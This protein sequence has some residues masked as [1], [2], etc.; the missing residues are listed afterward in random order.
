[1]FKK[2]TLAVLLA[3]ALVQSAL[4]QEQKTIK[5][6]PQDL[7]AAIRSL[8]E[9][10]G[11]QVLFAAEDL[12]GMKSPALE[13]SMP[14][15]EAL[16]RLLA[17]SGYSFKAT[18]PSTYVIERAAGEPT[19]LPEV[20]VTAPAES[21]YAVPNATAATKMDMPIHDIPQSIEVRGSQLLEDLGGTHNVYEAGKTVAG[22]FDVA[23]GNASPGINVPAFNIRGYASSYLR[24]GGLR[25]NGWIYTMDMASIDRI[26]FLK[27]PASVLYGSPG[28][29]GNYGGLVNYVSKR[30]RAD[31]LTELEFT[32]GSYDYYR[33]SL[34]FNHA[35]NNDKSLLFRF[36]GAYT[37]TGSFVDEA[38]AKTWIVAPELSYQLT[39]NDKLTIL[40][41]FVQSRATPVTGLPLTTESFDVPYHRNFVDPDFAHIDIDAYTAFVSYEHQFNPNW[42]LTL[43]SSVGYAY[44]DDYENNV[45]FDS[46]GTNTWQMGGSY[47]YF[48]NT[49]VSIDPRL[50]GK[51]DTGPMGH[52]LLFGFNWQ[53]DQYNTTGTFG[54]NVDLGGATL[55]TLVPPANGVYQAAWNSGPL[56]S[57]YYYS[58][59]YYIAPYVQDLIS[60]GEHVK[61]LAGVRYDNINNQVGVSGIFAS[62]VPQF[63]QFDVTSDHFSPRF[64]AVWQ[65]VKPTSIYASYSQGYVPNIGI[66]RD[67]TELPPEEGELMEVGLKQEIT[68]KLTANLAAYQITQKNMTDA[69]PANTPSE[70]FLILLGKTRSQGVELD[71]NGQITHS[72]RVTAAAAVMKAW[73]V[74]GNSSLPSGNLL[75]NAPAATF[76]LFGVYSFDG[77]L[78]GLELGGGGYY[79]SHV[80][81][82]SAH[83]MVMP[84]T[85]QF[86]A[87]T[88]YRFN[89]HWRMQVDVKNLADR[90]NYFAS[91]GGTIGRSQP[92][93]AYA[94]LKASF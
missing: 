59:N 3:A 14:A 24:D 54:P 85:I 26:E 53:M 38:H 88:A 30:P 55:A 28:Q 63:D 42:K 49:S 84:E 52:Q 45:F 74:D 75:G 9:Q 8:A 94:T 71:L 37:D 91:W 47:W 72:F 58:D 18:G 6:E 46:G 11:I 64:G 41:E 48:R 19:E 31:S 40:P 25:V 32:G 4:A 61:L 39:P 1:M 21:G 82:D 12:K 77:A 35:L 5:L 90:H 27:G 13:G 56:S 7:A 2:L 86:D 87:M 16:K 76:N 50:E 66:T 20:N 93:T 69:D 44:T 29:S 78:T 10:T 80:Y 65:P 68:N 23:Q 89:K 17:G 70:N 67:H 51:F 73:I 62:G 60:I 33:G 83:T 81:S 22:V 92:L 57:G 79:A 15:D 36:N 43:D 34:D